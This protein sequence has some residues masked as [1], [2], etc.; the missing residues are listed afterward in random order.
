MT[1]KTLVNHPS[2]RG[3]YY[4]IQLSGHLLNYDVGYWEYH[5]IEETYFYIR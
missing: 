5:N 1:E 2:Y 4:W 3:W